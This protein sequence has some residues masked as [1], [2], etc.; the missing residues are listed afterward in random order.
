MGPVL[1]AV[2]AGTTVHVTRNGRPLC[3][4]VPPKNNDAFTAHEGD[5]E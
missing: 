5:P 3:S 2:L 4:L 1:D